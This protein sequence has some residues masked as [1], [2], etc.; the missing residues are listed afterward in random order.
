MNKWNDKLKLFDKCT[1]I[2]FTIFSPIHVRWTMINYFADIA[3]NS[4]Y[5][6]LLSAVIWRHTM[7]NIDFSPAESFFLLSVSIRL[8]EI[9]VSFWAAAWVFPHIVYPTF[10]WSAHFP[11]SSWSGRCEEKMQ[12]D[13]LLIE[14]RAEKGKAL[15]LTDESWE[16][17]FHL[18]HF[19][20][21]HRLFEKCH[22]NCMRKSPSFDPSHPH[23]RF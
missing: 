15:Q 16:R 14:F 20:N 21:F 4:D 18:T 9:R 5:S 19:T 12:I 10:I 3:A 13:S 2:T 22:E 6:L 1:I 23:H 11:C 17:D 8:E 7:T